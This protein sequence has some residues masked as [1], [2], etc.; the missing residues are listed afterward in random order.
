MRF[1]P[2]VG[3]SLLVVAVGVAT[4]ATAEKRRAAPAP[5]PAAATTQSEAPS[6]LSEFRFGFS[7]Q[8]PWGP[9]NGSG[10]LS[11]EVLFAKPFEPADLFASY[12][13]PRPHV[14]GSLDFGGQPSLAYAGLTWSFDVAPRVF[15]EAAL[16]G[17]VQNDRTSPF[18]AAFRGQTAGCSPL[19]REAGGVGYRLS[20]NWNVMA[21]VEHMPNGG[22]CSDNKSLTNIGARFCYSF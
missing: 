18:E 14:G 12:F 5:V 22:A 2:I 9:D 6:L 1:R 4:S 15:V 19:F 20:R 16:S 7:A 21:L 17:A 13:I 8:N 3:L 10:A 11:G